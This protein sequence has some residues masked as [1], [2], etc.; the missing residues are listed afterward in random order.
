MQVRLRA[1]HVDL[2]I[3]QATQ[4]VADRRHVAIE[5]R[6]VADDDDVGLEQVLVGLDEV[7]E[8]GA[9]HLF[10]AFEDD[11]DVHRQRAGLRQVRFDGLHVHEDL[12]LVVDRAARVELAV[13]HRGFERRRRPELQRIDRLHV[14]VAV[15]EDGGRAS[16]AEPFGVD[17]RMPGRL[18]ETGAVHA[19]AGEFGGRPLGAAPHVGGVFRQGRDAGNG[20][21]ALEL[22][23]EPVA[24]QIDEID[25]LFHGMLRVR[26]GRTRFVTVTLHRP[27][28]RHQPASRHTAPS[29]AARASPSSSTRCASTLS[30]AMATRAGWR[31]R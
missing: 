27:G 22:L 10:L 20:E 7:V 24:V 3:G 25:D 30:S 1:A 9:A 13:A 31:S 26:R 28:T 19:D 17:H 2:E 23:D 15:E 5:H 16:G 11:L 4:A 14:V 6:R 18:D 8:V 29:R 21:V 12:A